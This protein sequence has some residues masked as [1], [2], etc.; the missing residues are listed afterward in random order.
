[1]SSIEHAVIAEK[2]NRAKLEQRRACIRIAQFSQL[3]PIMTVYSVSRAS[4][5]TTD[6]SVA[7]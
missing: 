7:S 3:I 1:M 2:L 4:D 6:L 5:K